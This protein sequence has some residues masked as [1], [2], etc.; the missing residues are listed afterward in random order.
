MCGGRGAQPLWGLQE[1]GFVW[2]AVGVLFFQFPSAVDCRLKWR[3]AAWHGRASGAPSIAAVHPR[4]ST[5]S[6]R[7]KLSVRLTTC[8]LHKPSTVLA[9][10]ARLIGPFCQISGSPRVQ[11][12][13][14]RPQFATSLVLQCSLP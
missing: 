5:M 6:T 11:R 12:N 9:V 14:L 13:T 8:H 2:L 7:I 1:S 4:T 10:N 3:S